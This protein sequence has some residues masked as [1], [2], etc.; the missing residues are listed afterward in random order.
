MENAWKTILLAEGEAAV[1]AKYK[2]LNDVTIIKS[3]SLRNS[4]GSCKTGRTNTLGAFIH[5][6]VDRNSQIAQNPIAYEDETVS[7]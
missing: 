1:T 3:D 2:S 5:E 7:R 4:R 6:H